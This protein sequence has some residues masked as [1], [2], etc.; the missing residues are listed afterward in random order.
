MAFGESGSPLI[1]SQRNA[2]SE[3]AIKQS[4]WQQ[5]MA[6]GIAGGSTRQYPNLKLFTQF[7]EAKIE[8]FD[9]AAGR[10]TALKDY[11]ITFDPTI[12]E[13]YLT[14]VRARSSFVW[15]DQLR[16]ECTGAVSN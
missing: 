1:P 13:A 2:N 6:T 10:V 15:A 12:R 3:L 11:R 4:W 9:S 5:L 16:Y 7:E 8:T 14:D